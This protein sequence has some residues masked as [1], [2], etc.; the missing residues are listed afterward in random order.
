MIKISV[1]IPAYNAE[2]HIKRCIQS[3][4]VQDLPAGE[5]EA[6]VIND[7]SND[8]TEEILAELGTQYHFMKY[9]TTENGGLS[10]ARTR[11]ISEASG[12]Y[13]IFLDSDDSLQNNVLGSIY[14]KMSSDGLDMLHLSYRYIFSNGKTKD[15]VFKPGRK[16]PAVYRGTEF[17]L[18]D[19]YTPAVCIYAFRKD[20]L[21]ENDLHM[22]SI[23]HE[24]EEFTP[25]AIFA[26]HRI[27][28]LPLIFY[29]YYQNADSFM[30]RYK[31]KNFYDMVKAMSMLNRFKLEKCG[32]NKELTDY[33]DNHISLRI[34]MI[35]KRSIRD[36]YHTQDKLLDMIREAGLYPLHLKKP[37]LYSKLFNSSPKRFEKIY[38]I[39]KRKF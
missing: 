23:G 4:A 26:A 34:L 31:E 33:F 25:R 15:F 35:F 21:T 9:V 14:D 24:D 6:I 17:L 12:R 20:F 8:D 28:Y 36:G 38:R 18:E 27:A 3:L 29:N 2:K 11:G 5:Y 7:G 13:L 30:N 37:T 22:Q 39:I 10:R 16:Q 19:N 32:G 1:I